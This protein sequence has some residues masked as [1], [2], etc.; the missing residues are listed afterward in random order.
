MIKLSGRTLKYACSFPADTRKV[1]GKVCATWVAAHFPRLVASVLC[2]VNCSL[3][4]ASSQSELIQ[5]TGRNIL[6]PIFI[7]EATR[8]SRVIPQCPAVTPHSS[9]TVWIHTRRKQFSSCYFMFVLYDMTRYLI[10]V[11]SLYHF[12]D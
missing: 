2:V 5:S 9:P 7:V 3:V 4:A 8:S 6:S 12:M 10:E 1:H 11:T